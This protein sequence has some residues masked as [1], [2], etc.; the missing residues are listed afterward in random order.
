MTLTWLL[1]WL[2]GTAARKESGK[3]PPDRPLRAVTERNGPSRPNPL[4][5][6]CCDGGEIR[7]LRAQSTVL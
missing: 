4:V 7:I 2:A 6:A 3:S 1:D 5:S